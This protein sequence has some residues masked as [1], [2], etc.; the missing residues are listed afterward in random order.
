[1]TAIDQATALDEFEMP[2][3]DLGAGT[4]GDKSAVTCS[5]GKYELGN[6]SKALR[7]N[8]ILQI[9]KKKNFRWECH[10][11]TGRIQAKPTTKTSWGG[12]ARKMLHRKSTRASRSLF[13]TSIARNET[14][15]TQPCTMY[16][17]QV[18]KE[19]GRIMNKQVNRT[20]TSSAEMLFYENEKSSKKFKRYAY[21][22]INL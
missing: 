15:V 22:W 1:M 4:S 2:S 20:T 21:P 11:L 7:Q 5:T 17:A 9:V 6:C 12:R 16:F 13:K 10:S 19:Y 8:Q 3:L 18:Q 14:L